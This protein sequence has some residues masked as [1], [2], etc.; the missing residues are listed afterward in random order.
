MFFAATYCV[1]IPWG[2]MVLCLGFIIAYWVFKVNFL[3]LEIIYLL[4][5][6]KM[7]NDSYLKL[8]SFGPV[9]IYSP[10][11]GYWYHCCLMENS[12]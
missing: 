5:F 3:I 12:G 8:K 10:Y 1:I 9:G 7:F 11:Y 6:I 2:S 4:V